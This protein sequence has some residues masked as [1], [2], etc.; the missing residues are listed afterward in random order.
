MHDHDRRDEG[1]GMIITRTETRS[2]EELEELVQEQNTLRTTYDPQRSAVVR[3]P[4]G[5]G[6]LI[7]PRYGALVCGGC[8]R[9]I[10]REI[11]R[12]GR[13]DGAEVEAG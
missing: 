1:Q 2:T 6:T 13:L 4:G 5:C 12:G 11:R 8:Y 9:R 7:S 10:R 3:C